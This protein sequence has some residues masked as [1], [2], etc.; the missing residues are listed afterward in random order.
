MIFG[1]SSALAS[2]LLLSWKS[3]SNQAKFCATVTGLVK[4]DVPVQVLVERALEPLRQR[5]VTILAQQKELKGRCLAVEAELLDA[6]RRAG[7]AQAQVTFQESRKQDL[8]RTISTLQETM[9][10]IETKKNATMEEIRQKAREIGDEGADAKIEEVRKSPTLQQYMSKGSKSGSLIQ[11]YAKLHFEV[12]EF[13]SKIQAAQTGSA[14][15]EQVAAEHRKLREVAK[16]QASA[17]EAALQELQK[18]QQAMRRSL[19]DVAKD[20]AQ[21]NLQR[22]SLERTVDWAKS[23][24][25][26]T[27]VTVET[28]GTLVI[29]RA[30][31]IRLALAISGSTHLQVLRD[32]KC[33]AFELRSERRIASRLKKAGFSG[34][35]LKEMGFSARELH[36]ADIRILELFTGEELKAA[37]FSARELREIGTTVLALMELGFQVD[38]LREAGC[39]SRSL[40][41]ARNYRNGTS[42]AELSLQGFEATDLK[43]AGFRACQLFPECWGP[44]AWFKYQLL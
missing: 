29:T 20:E 3:I 11:E 19:D 7:E 9:D 32:L 1:G 12:E 15:N 42:I 28:L 27:P 43:R 23:T 21:V 33:A 18:D 16:E 30:E 41:A 6:R 39:D 31:A 22:Q 4:V 37:G 26:V 44:T 24:S 5:Q 17:L 40:Q 2:R 25:P 13:K 38:E 36:K 34:E 14:K 10:D 8:Q 35:E